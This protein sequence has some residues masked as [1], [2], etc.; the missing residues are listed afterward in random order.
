VHTGKPRPGNERFDIV[1]V[2]PTMAAEWLKLNTRNRPL[3]PATVNKYVRILQRSE[4][5]LTG[6]CVCFDVN[7]QLAN[8][9]HRLA[10]IIQS[11]IAAPFGVMWGL[12]EMAQDAMDGNLPR[13]LADALAL[14]GEV[15]THTLAAAIRALQKLEY[16]R[17][18]G[19]VNYMDPSAEN[20]TTIQSLAFFRQHQELRDCLPKTRAT[21]RKLHARPGM[22]AALYW[23]FAQQD[24]ELADMFFDQ[25]ET[26]TM[27]PVGHAAAA[28]RVGLPA[29]SPILQLREWLINQKAEKFSKPP[30]Y[31]EAAMF[32]KAWYLWCRSETVGQLSWNYG[33]KVKEK[34]PIGAFTAAT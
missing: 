34:F 17:T 14:R 22:S 21:C 8:G 3:R 2:T 27:L 29:K 23:L 32:C 31:R 9:Q 13:I 1:V 19:R 15:A 7:D 30:D 16:I 24:Q 6:D 28:E 12:D 25:L 18:S 11:G 10:A 5:V 20:P 33:P 4:W 26:G